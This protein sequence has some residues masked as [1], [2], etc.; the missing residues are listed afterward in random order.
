M[1]SE[2]TAAFGGQENIS[3]QGEVTEIPQKAK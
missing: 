2:K 1:Q 3:V